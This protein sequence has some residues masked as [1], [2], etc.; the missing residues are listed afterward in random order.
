VGLSGAQ[1][2]GMFESANQIWSLNLSVVFKHV[3]PPP[4]FHP[5]WKMQFKFIS[6][7]FH[8]S[9][10]R[11]KEVNI[12][13]KKYKNMGFSNPSLT[14]TFFINFFTN[15]LLVNNYLINSQGRQLCEAVH[16]CSIFKFFMS[17]FYA[18]KD[19]QICSSFKGS[20]K[21]DGFVIKDS[22]ICI[23]IATFFKLNR[24]WGVDMSPLL[25]YYFLCSDYIHIY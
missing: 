8:I 10:N 7:Y 14:L 17:I 18:F 24:I 2:F 9:L 23:C 3:T 15:F 21:L 20:V 5:S 19:V 4:P 12:N 22:R 11:L 16:D 25:N 1:K 6:F 13:I